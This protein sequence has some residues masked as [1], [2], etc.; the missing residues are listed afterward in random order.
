[1]PGAPITSSPDSPADP[2]LVSVVLNFLDAERFIEEAIQSVY[3]QSY[4][5]WELLLIDD[6]S[7]DA[8][9]TIAKRHAAS[10]PGRVRYLEFPGHEN[11]G[12]SAAR[13]LGLREARGEFVAFLDSDDLW[14]PKRLEWS[15]E[16]LRSY[17]TADM[18]YGESEYWYSWTGEGA[19]HAD[20]VQPQGFDADR[21]VAA[22][23]LLVRYLTHTAAVPCPTSI[24]VRRDAALSCGGFVEAFRGM[25]DDQAFMARFCLY[26]D[27]YVA[28]ECWDRYRQHDAS[29]CAVAEREGAVALA[30]QAYLRWL[31]GFLEEQ[32]MPGTRVWDALV[33][34]EQV[35]RYPGKSL[36]A[37][38]G[39]MM[40]RAFTRARMLTR[41]R[42]RPV[43]PSS[44]LPP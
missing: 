5:A 18:A 44:P 32:G 24:T 27:A 9:T 26:H 20:R 25:H 37:R 8:S 15:V 28:R 17:P 2:G 38:V 42:V 22:P 41:P 31:R 3:A 14:L 36:R 34:A 4:P 21:V 39:R 30:R 40:L 33:Y 1:M 23:E 12:A 29:L 6:G 7:S 43:P 35:E 10:D 13:N 16:L 11:R 19:P